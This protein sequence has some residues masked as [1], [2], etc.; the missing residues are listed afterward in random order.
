MS[1]EKLEVLHVGI[2]RDEDFGTADMAIFLTQMKNLKVRGREV[3]TYRT[4]YLIGTGRYR[5]LLL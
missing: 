5:Y 4:W 2:F 3:P 1:R